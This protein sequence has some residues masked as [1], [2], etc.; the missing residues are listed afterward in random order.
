[1]F[2]SK[3]EFYRLKLNNRFAKL[4]RFEHS[5]QA[6]RTSSQLKLNIDLKF[7]QEAQQK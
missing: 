6:E 5:M 7:S 2:E 4:N 1:M 3:F